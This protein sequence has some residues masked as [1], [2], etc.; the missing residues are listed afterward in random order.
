MLFRKKLEKTNESINKSAENSNNKRASKKQIKVYRIAQN[1]IRYKMMREDGICCLGDDLYS[2]SIKF[3]DINYEIAPEDTQRTI[4]AMY[5]NL[6]NS[7][8]ND[9][10]VSLVINNRLINHDE[11]E[12][13][14]LM[15]HHGD[16]LDVLRSE[17]NQHLINNMNKGNNSIVSDKMF[18][19]TCKE[20]NVLEAKKILNDIER[21]FQE[22]L[23]K[24]GCETEIMNGLDRMTVLHSI[25]KPEEILKYTYQDLTI[26]TSTKD[27]I[28]PYSYEFKKDYFEMGNRFCSTMVLLNYPT[29]FNDDLIYELSKMENNLLITLHMKLLSKDKAVE[30]INR[31][32]Q[33][34][35]IQVDNE[36]RKRRKMG[37]FDDKLPPNLQKQQNSIDEWRNAVEKSDEHIFKTKLVIMINAASYEEMLQVR[38]DVVRIGK[39]CGC[40]IVPME[41]EQEMG[42]NEALP[43]GI[44]SKAINRLLLT[45]NV[46]NIMPFTSQELLDD[47]NPIFYGV[48]HTTNNM[49]LCNRTNLPNSNGF[50]LGKSGMGKSFK[51]KEELSW[52]MMKDEEAD[53]IIIDPQGEYKIIAETFNNYSNKKICDV[54]EISSN[55]KLYFNPFDGDV[56]QPDF[57]KQKAEFIQTIM[58]EMIG[59]GY[60]TP[61]QKSI[62]DQVVYKVYQDYLLN[63]EQ[64][65]FE[66]AVM[67]TLETF[68]NV[69]GQNNDPISKQMY[70]ALWIYVYG[71]YDLF[72]HQSNVNVDSKL[73]IYDI[74]NLGNTI[75]TLGQKVILESIREKIKRNHEK[76]R[77]TYVYIDEIYLLL[78][79]EYSANFLYEFWKWARKYGAVLTGM[80]QNVSD[81]L[82]SQ[83]GCTMLSNSEFFIILGQDSN[84]VMQ[85]QSLLELSKEQAQFVLTAGRGE[86]LIRYGNTIIPFTDSFPKETICYSM[87][88]TDPK[89]S[90]NNQANELRLKQEE[91]KKVQEEIKQ[92]ELAEALLSTQIKTSTDKHTLLDETVNPDNY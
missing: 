56:F 33:F 80:T 81:L 59:N 40:E 6:L 11:F 2:K 82:R 18:T 54:L 8:G 15:K 58:A 89:A 92:R 3:K 12:R 52:V 87:W 84:D 21:G 62:T 14:V 79:D 73:L 7:L 86:G 49:I 55:S 64:E 72:A 45:D 25:T 61:E 90:K 71:S 26:G 36:T 77:R 66:Q 1:M 47:K 68:Y 5:K 60:L 4:I 42:F 85:L 48:N 23:F 13:N 20:E 43:L 17:V 31:K 53:V 46:A 34:T 76:K 9:I 88:N 44:P 35:E 37:D 24:L 67:P 65:N 74:S 51:V 19:F 70:R 39:R 57:I 69:L 32:A 16:G 10:D 38:R 29:Y 50:I 91:A 22:Q 78:K 63:L 75:V 28:S 83:K 41:Y 27:W 30:L